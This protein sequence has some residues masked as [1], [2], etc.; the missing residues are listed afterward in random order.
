M[1]PAGKPLDLKT[2]G[3][4]SCIYG[5]RL[6]IPR[7]APKCYRQKNRPGLVCQVSSSGG[8]LPGRLVLARVPGARKFWN[9][10][11]YECR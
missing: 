4:V 9:G 10:I 8:G 7:M 5:R 3:F 6:M 2:Y 11:Y 1:S